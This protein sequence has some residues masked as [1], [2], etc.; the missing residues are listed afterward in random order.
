[1]SHLRRRK[2]VRRKISGT[3]GRP[4]LSVFR[5][6]KHIYAQ[7]INDERGVTIAEASTLSPELKENLT[8][9]GNVKAAESVGALIAQKAKQQEIEAVVFDRGGHLY[10]GRIKALAEAAKAEG[11]KF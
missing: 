1:M 7:L 6:S 3:E 2:R 11:L 8:N 9:G 4:R 10:H 5:S